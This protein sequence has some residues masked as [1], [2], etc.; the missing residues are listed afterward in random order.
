M[1]AHVFMSIKLGLYHLD[2]ARTN[3]LSIFLSRSGILTKTTASP[4]KHISIFIRI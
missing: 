4:V 2:V 1:A 3:I